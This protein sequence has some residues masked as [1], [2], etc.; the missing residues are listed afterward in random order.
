M[1]YLKLFE[2][3]KTLKDIETYFEENKGKNTEKM[4]PGSE[5]LFKATL[6]DESHEE[7]YNNVIDKIVDKVAYFKKSFPWLGTDFIKQPLHELA[8]SPVN[9]KKKR[10]QNKVEKFLLQNRKLIYDGLKSLGEKYW[11]N[12]RSGFIMADFNDTEWKIISVSKDSLSDAYLLVGIYDG[13]NVIDLEGVLEKEDMI[14]K[15]FV[16]QFYIDN[17]KKFL[18]GQS[19]EDDSVFII[20]Q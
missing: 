16:K 19:A 14:T 1:K 12:T 4:L 9:Q 8:L 20:T 10:P 18:V 11:G 15:K 17:P 13:K 6:S 3:F 5:V 7:I 2:Q